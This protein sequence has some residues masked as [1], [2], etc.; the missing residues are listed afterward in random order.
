MHFHKKLINYTKDNEIDYKFY[1]FNYKYINISLFFL[2]KQG[3]ETKFS[4]AEFEGH[5][6]KTY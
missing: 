3:G 2:A 5:K 1:Y 4:Q 6:K